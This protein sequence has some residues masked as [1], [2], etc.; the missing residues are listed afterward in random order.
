MDELERYRR[1]G[2]ETSSLTSSPPARLRLPLE[3]EAFVACWQPWV[4]QARGAGVLEI[5]R[6]HLP[7]LAFPIT[8]GIS[9]SE[10]YQAATRRGIPPSEAPGA[11]DADGAGGLTLKA[12]ESLELLLHRSAAGRVPMLVTRNREDFVSLVRALAYRNEPRDIPPSQGATMLAGYNNWARIHAHRRAWEEGENPGGSGAARAATWREQFAR[13]RERRE[14]YQ[15]R[16][17]ILSDGPYSGVRAAELGLTDGAWKD[18]SLLIR[19]EHECTHYLTRR[20]FDAMRNHLLDEL[21]ADYAGITAAIG[22]YRSDWFLRFLGL[23]DDGYRAGGRLEIYLGKPPLGA[24]SFR[25][26]QALA[27]LAAHRL[28][29]FDARFFARRERNARHRTAVVLGLARVGL[30]GLTGEGGAEK[31]EKAA[32]ELDGRLEWRREG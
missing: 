29:S 8:A 6:P 15:D 23:E 14:L 20:L 5:L 18:L 32:A 22:D 25:D 31:L 26:L 11:S 30:A 27:R 7:Q 28:E 9:A 4:D 16:L 24:G 10:P 1:D 17:M 12:P 13:I 19:R 3:D 2:F 21:M